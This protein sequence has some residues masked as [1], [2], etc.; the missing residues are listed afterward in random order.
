MDL[1]KG[2][3]ILLYY[4]LHA[5]EVRFGHLESVRCQQNIIHLAD[6]RFLLPRTFIIV[7][8]HSD[9]YNYFKLILRNN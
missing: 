4:T 7:F 3:Y 6:I 5:F 8:A 1:Y 9:F 2:N